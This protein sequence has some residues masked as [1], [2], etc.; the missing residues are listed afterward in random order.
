MAKN[1]DELETAD[2]KT[3]S[4][5]KKVRAHR[6]VFNKGEEDNTK[7]REESMTDDQKAE[8][9]RLVKGMKKS[10]KG[11]VAKYGKDRAKSVMYAT[12]T[13]NAMKEEAEQL[14]E[15]SKDTIKKYKDHAPWNQIRHAADVYDHENEGRPGAKAPASTYRN[16]ENR[17]K[18]IARA[19]ARLKKEN[20]ETEEQ[21]MTDKLDELNKSTLASY[22]G[23][24]SQ[25]AA[26]QAMK[27]GADHGYVG[28]VL[29]RLTNIKKAANKLAKEE[30]EQIDELSKTTLGNYKSAA[31]DDRAGYHDSRNSGDREEAEYAKKKIIKRSS[32]IASA[33]KRLGEEIELNE[34][35]FDHAALDKKYG[36]PSK[37]TGHPAERASKSHTIHDG[38][39]YH[40]QDPRLHAKVKAAKAA[41]SVKKEEVELDEAHPFDIPKSS[42]MATSTATKHDVKKTSTGTV[43]TKQRDADGNAK[44]FKRDPDEAKRG[45][46]RPKKNSFSEAVEFLMTLDEEQFNDVTSEGYDAFFKSYEQVIAQTK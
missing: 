45:R 4:N 13:K 24:A 15:L 3:T 20:L 46:G 39:V 34:E 21:S 44:E 6:I 36:K 41:S 33:N 43:Y 14:D 29:K 32:G 26:G 10:Y 28:K 31:K 25:S 5:G 17:K 37:V 2:Y 40:W 30:V 16:L 18:G 23:K 38:M 35:E 12:A 7:L 27:A 22:V 1:D 9:E 8:R 11:F 42:G 19:D